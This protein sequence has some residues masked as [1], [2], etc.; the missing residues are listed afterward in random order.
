MESFP[1][2]FLRRLHSPGGEQPESTIVCPPSVILVPFVKEIM[3]LS[4][5]VHAC[6]TSVEPHLLISERDQARSVSALESFV[7]NSCLG[8]FGGTPQYSGFMDSDTVIL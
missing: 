2:F 3:G 1:D 4:M 7:E 5:G 6:S 8:S